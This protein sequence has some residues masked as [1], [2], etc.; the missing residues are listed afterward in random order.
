MP[1][2][3]KL[4]SVLG[5]TLSGGKHHAGFLDPEH[6]H[7]RIFGSVYPTHEVPARD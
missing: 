7:I 4:T 2:Y 5:A 3:S 6:M 1:Y